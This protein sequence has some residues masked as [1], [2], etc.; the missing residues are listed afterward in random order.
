MATDKPGFLV[1]FRKPADK[2]S[3]WDLSSSSFKDGIAGVGVGIGGS[4]VAVG[5]GVTSTSV[6]V[7]MICRPIFK[8]GEAWGT[9]TW[10]FGEHEARLIPIINIMYLTNLYIEQLPVLYLREI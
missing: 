2:R 8:V 6:G 5:D 9:E 3:T 10:P 1:L 4:S 7:G